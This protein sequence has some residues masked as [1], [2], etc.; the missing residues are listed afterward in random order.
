MQLNWTGVYPALTTQF[1]ADGALDWG[2]YRH[3]VEAQLQAGVQGLIV[4]GSLGE[5]SSLS[6]EE[7][8]LIAEKTLA[9]SAGRVPVILN[10]AERSNRDAIYLAQQAEQRGVHGLMLLPPMQYKA[11]EREVVAYFRDVASATRL[12]IMIYNNPVDYKIFVS[13]D[14]FRQLMVHDNIQ[15]VKESTRDLTN[16][17]RMR[18]AFGDRFKIMGGVDTLTVECLVMGADGLVAGLVNAFPRETV[19][20]YELI[21]Q[22]RIAEAREL[23]AWFLP[24][25]E[26][27]IHPKLVQYIKLAELAV[28]LGNEYVRPPRLGLEGEER[29]RVWQII[30]DALARR[31]AIEQ[32][33]R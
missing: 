33:V 14:M 15:A 24:L 1:T 28:G 3:N 4:C 8:L 30:Q 25:L 13:V 11:D 5:G 20:I 22:G 6:L 12:P 31:P 17:T 7:K 27:D 32:L 9:I 2:T 26:L 19:V 23:F 16:I 18:N 10:L 29:Q 21:Q